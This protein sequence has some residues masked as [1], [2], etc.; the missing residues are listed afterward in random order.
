MSNIHS[1]LEYIARRDV[2]EEINLWPQIAARIERKDTVNMNPKLKLVWT[3]VLV[4][5][6]LVLATTAAY[7]VYRYFADPGLQAVNEAGMFTDINSTAQPTVLPIQTPDAASGAATVVGL[8]QTQNGVTMRLEWVSLLDPRQIF[9]ISAQGLDAQME[10]GMPQVTYPG[11]TPQQYGGAIF[12]LNDGPLVTGRYVSYQ[13]LRKDDQFGGQVDM[14]IDIPLLQRT[15]DELAQVANFHFDLKDVQVVVPNGWGGS[16]AYSMRV[17]GLEVRQVHTI[18]TPRYTEAR[19]CYDVPAAGQSWVIRDASIQFSGQ[20][21]SGETASMQ[22]L[23]QVAD[24][25]GQGCADVRFAKGKSPGNISLNITVNG[26]VL[27]N[28]QEQIDS[29][30]QLYTGLVDDIQVA[31]APNLGPASTPTSET[32]LEAQ[33]NGDLTVTLLSVYADANRLAVTLRVE[34]K[35]PD[36][37][38]S[39]NLTDAEGYDI[40]SSYG[41]GSPEGQPNLYILTFVP[42][43]MSHS[44]AQG[45]SPKAPLAERHFEGKLDVTIGMMD[46]IQSDTAFHFD[47][48]VPVYPALI[49]EPK[50][51]LTANGIEMHLEKL[52]I[53][54]SYTRLYICYKKPSPN[55]WMIGASSTLQIGPD[56]VHADS[57]GLV[58]DSDYNTG[59]G[60][61]PDFVSSTRTGRCVKLGYPVGHHNRPE[62]LTLTIPELEQS[63][64]EVI[65]DDQVKKAQAEMSAQGIEID[66]VTFTGNGGG[67]GGPNIKKKPAGMSDQ[68]VM[69]LF[70]AALGYYHPGPW[71]FT[72]NI[73]P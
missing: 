73:N 5:L 64:P 21:T 55:D 12:S 60:P 26:L 18:V 20:Q 61:D 33:T 13:I 41:M 56:E 37:Y 27:D 8:E 46:G 47:L 7:A 59:K 2:P 15:G 35:A 10:F 70:Y 36:S 24:H 28:S 3:V 65:P 67:G 19:L 40:N 14:Q 52:K 25:E 39:A 62:T 69:R 42:E 6:G 38:V 48:N 66:Y 29:T 72:I 51:I 54:P 68:E 71:V 23:T 1:A 16:N 9:E 50:Q 44:A 58:A 45:F 57:Y 30:W 32:P 17:N 53:T 22:R 63:L 43:D 11:V 34:G 49:V 4:V 31:R